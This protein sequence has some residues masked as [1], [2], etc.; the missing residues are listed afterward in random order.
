M[1]ES[2]SFEECG[3]DCGLDSNE[4]EVFSNVEE[5]SLV[6]GVFDGA[7]GGDGDEDVVIGEGVEM[8]LEKEAWVEA[9][10]IENEENEDDG[11]SGEGDYLIRR[12]RDTVKSLMT[13]VG[14]PIN[15]LAVPDIFGGRPIN[16]KPDKIIDWYKEGLKIDI[17]K[18]ETAS[19]FSVT[20]S[21][22]AS[23]GVR[24]L[25]T[26]SGCNRHKET[27]EDSR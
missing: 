15:N 20:L 4:D 9:M 16:E 23:D 1:R 18:V 21:G 7:F 19:G 17:Q 3:E 25:A 22:F 14:D 5:V 12:R 6:D 10:K 11:K 24:T 8:A 27:L 2:G 13:P 26:T